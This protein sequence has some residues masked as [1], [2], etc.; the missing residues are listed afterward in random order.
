MNT[1][2]KY[3]IDKYPIGEISKPPIHDNAYVS[4][5]MKGDAYLP[6]IFATAYSI[7]R[8]NP[9]ADIVVMVTPD[10]SKETCDIILRVASH[11]FY[12]NYLAFNTKPLRSDKQRAQYSNW[13]D[14][15]YTKWISLTLPYK[16]IIF[17]DADIITLKNIDHLFDL[18]APA[19]CFNCAYVKPL[20]RIPDFL[21]GQRGPDG[22]LKH[23]EPVS[24]ETINKIINNNG[25]LCS[26][27][28]ILLE[29][30][31]I[32]YYAFCATMESLTKKEPFG[33]RCASGVDEQAICYFYANVKHESFTNIHHRYN[34]V[35]R[36]EGYFA[37][38]D[39]GIVLHY[40]SIN[41]PWKV[42]YNDWPDLVCW[43]KM[44]AEGLQQFKLKAADVKLKDSDI[45]GAK[46]A[47][48]QFT[49]DIFKTINKKITSCLQLIKLK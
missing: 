47:P 46:K 32:N 38:N 49:I 13:I 12:V 8:T 11:L 28:S 39:Y 15:S 30:S 17:M 16:R 29:P 6:G 3:L 14:V 10:V 5:I 1:I 24:I 31:F 22:Y 45:N 35:S 23:G 42:A 4:L 37:P 33:M 40:N 21:I 25:M 20:G 2:P 44:V 18:H 41:K 34:Y 19:G 43:Y 36:K 7:Y 27:S 9:T 26:A 48:D